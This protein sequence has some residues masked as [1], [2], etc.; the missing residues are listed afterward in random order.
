MESQDWEAKMT[1]RIIYW[2]VE[3][4]DAD[5]ARVTGVYTSIQDLIEVGLKPSDRNIRLSLFK[6]DS[7]DGRMGEWKGPD[8]DGLRAELEQF[9]ETGEFTIEQCNEL[10][11]YL[12]GCHT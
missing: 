1:F 2:V 8:F 10:A 9:I 3:Q 5:Q 4:F 12:V 6:L 11:D 7:P